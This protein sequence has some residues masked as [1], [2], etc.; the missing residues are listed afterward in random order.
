MLS[1][2]MTTPKIQVPMRA[3]SVLVG[4]RAQLRS[5]KLTRSR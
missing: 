5:G 1:S 3:A 2:A 4:S